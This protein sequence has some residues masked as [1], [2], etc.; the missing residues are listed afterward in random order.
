MSGDAMQPVG[1]VK[2]A[3]TARR[4]G[5]TM[6]GSA[7]VAVLDQAAYAGG[8][9]LLAVILARNVAPAAYGVFAFTYSF[10]WLACTVH[11]AFVTDPMLVYG[12]STWKE[13]WPAYFRVLSGLHWR[14]CAVE[15]G[16]LAAAGAGLL[17]AGK[18][19]LGL[20]F[21]GLGLAT[22]FILDV[23]LLRRACF[24]ESKPAIAAE[25]SGLYLGV[26]ILVATLLPKLGA[27]FAVPAV[28]AGLAAGNA[29]L[30]LWVRRRLAVPDTA[31]VVTR[32]DVLRQHWSFG[33][34]AI[35]GSMLSWVPT[36][37]FY[38]MLPGAA[39][40]EATGALRA[41]MNLVQPPIQANGALGIY[42]VPYLA[43]RRRDAAFRRRA[44]VTLGLQVGS[45]LLYWL[46]LAAFA[47][48]ILTTLYRGR[49]DQQAHLLWYLGLIPVATAAITAVGS[50][51]RAVDRPDVLFYGY[52]AATI[53]TVTLGRWMS[54]RYGLW[55][56]SVG[57]L[58]AMSSVA[59]VG[60]VLFSRLTSRMVGPSKERL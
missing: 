18:T 31:P 13:N 41:L 16:A 39:G 12:A 19:E 47:H 43:R 37:F 55:G 24:V 52:L 38:V 33:R 11:C 20:A 4:S 49:Y 17:L 53:M 5:A 32:A 46:L 9:F 6:A 2:T 50:V 44:W 1:P 42:L 45:A 15:F 36:N 34:W 51:A 60:L 26:V 27:T 14:L 10:F 3:G 48:P 59:V 35:G 22:P 56:A 28:F 54:D 57:M 29:L 8:N 58:V 25:G 23:W 7:V 30:G 40:L 21:C